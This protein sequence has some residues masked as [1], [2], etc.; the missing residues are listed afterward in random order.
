MARPPS[1]GS[2]PCPTYPTSGPT[3]IAC[4]RATAPRP[5]LRRDAGAGRQHPRPLARGSSRASRR[6]EPRVARQ[7]RSRHEAPA[8]RERHRLQRLCRSGRSGARM[9]ARPRA[10][11]LARWR[12]GAP[13]RRHPAARAADRRRARR[14]A[15]RRSVCCATECCRPRCS[16]AARPSSAPAST[17]RR[18]RAGSSTPMPA[19]SRARRVAEWVVLGDQTDTAIGNGYVLAEPRGAQPRLGPAVPRLPH[20]AA[21]R[22]LHDHAGGVP[23]AVRARRRQDRD[24]EPRPGEPL[25]FQPRLS[26]ALPGLHRGRERRPHRPRQPR[27]PQDARR[28]AAGL[29]DRRQAARASPG[30]AAPAGRRARRDPGP[31][32]GRAQRRPRHGQPTGQRGAAEPHAGAVRGAPVPPGARR[33]ASARR[34]AHPLAGLRPRA[35]G[36]LAGGRIGCAP[37]PGRALVAAAAGIT[38][39]GDQAQVRGAAGHGGA[40]VGRGRAPA[41]RDHAILRRRALRPD[42]LGHA[43]LC[44]RHRGRLPHH[45]RRHGP[46]RRRGHGGDAAQRLRQQGSVD[47]RTHAGARAGQHPAHQHARGASAP[48]RPRPPE[49]DRRQS[50]LARPLCRAGR[51]HHARPAQRDVAV[52]RGRPARQRPLGPAPPVAAPARAWARAGGRGE[53]PRRLG[54]CRASSQGS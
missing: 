54:R 17:A 9:A 6:S 21:R 41:A 23:G 13:G 29:S 38:R 18:R 26:R 46:P 35:R 34:R 22:A 11:P 49:P 42:P 47:H 14:P 43:H 1:C 44:R 19:T 12:M 50:V 7:R 8:A 31:A 27:L 28:P 25:L 3:S 20:A 15:R 39:P 2:A 33:G 40:S 30:L 45:A 32:P 16:S 36:R 10:G 52:P 51:G 5:A 53:R 37:R 4:S 24:P 48:D